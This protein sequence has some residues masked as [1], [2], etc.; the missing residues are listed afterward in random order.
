M[1]NNNLQMI[2]LAVIVGFMLQGMMKNMCGGLLE[3][4]SVAGRAH[5]PLSLMSECTKT[6]AFDDG[7]CPLNHK[8]LL[9][10][11]YSRLPT[12]GLD[13]SNDTTTYCFPGY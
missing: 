11:E 10:S 4:M 8:C 1:D 5:S 13:H 2:V 12:D 3:A 9:W 7:P 6:G